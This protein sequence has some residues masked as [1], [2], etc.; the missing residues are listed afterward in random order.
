MYGKDADVLGG[1]I[2]RANRA[3]SPENRFITRDNKLGFVEVSCSNNGKERLASQ[4]TI[5]FMVLTRPQ[6]VRTHIQN[7]EEQ[8]F[9]NGGL[10]ILPEIWKGVR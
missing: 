1:T 7:Q 3:D 9:S 10:A 5:P 4:R 2:Q 6:G 8:V